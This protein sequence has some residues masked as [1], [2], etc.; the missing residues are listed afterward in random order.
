MTTDIEKIRILGVDPG[1]MIHAN[2]L[3]K[4]S[5]IERVFAPAVQ[6]Y[7]KIAVHLWPNGMFRSVQKSST[8]VERAAFGEDSIVSGES[9]DVY[10]N[11]NELALSSKESMD[12]TKQKL[13][14]DLSLELVML[15]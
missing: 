13:L 2:I 9:K 11:G 5:S 12:I 3:E 10:L 8:D 15:N 6:M 7:S 14:W 4:A 1:A